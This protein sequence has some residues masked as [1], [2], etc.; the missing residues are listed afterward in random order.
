MEYKEILKPILTTISYDNIE[1]AIRLGQDSLHQESLNPLL[2]LQSFYSSLVETLRCKVKPDI[3]ISIFL[4]F[5]SAVLVERQR[6]RLQEELLGI[7]A[8]IY[9]FETTDTNI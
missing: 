8:D 1:I 7:F 9:G 4:A 5:D 2:I 3:Q 6:N